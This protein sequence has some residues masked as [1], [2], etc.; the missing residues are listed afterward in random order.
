MV[1]CLDLEYQKNLTGR[2][3]GVEVGWPGVGNR[4][5]GGDAEIILGRR[6]RRE[7]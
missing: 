1:E 3:E 7:A 5:T 6:E 2:E 4:D